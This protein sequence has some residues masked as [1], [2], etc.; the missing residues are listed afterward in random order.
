MK[1]LLNIL[2]IC[3]LLT[4]T[5]TVFAKEKKAE[6]VKKDEII[7][8]VKP[9]K[10]KVNKKR[11]LKKHSAHNKVRLKSAKEAEGMY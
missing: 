1:K 6:K 8:I 4:T 7:Q 2:L 11:E 10:Q 5:T 9:E 3:S